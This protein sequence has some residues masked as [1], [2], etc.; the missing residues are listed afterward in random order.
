MEQWASE[1]RTKTQP[2]LLKITTHHGPG[3]TSS[4]LAW[5]QLKLTVGGKE[6]E[7][8]DVVITTFQVLASE[9]KARGQRAAPSD[10]D[11]SDDGLRKKLKRKKKVMAALY[12]V[13]WL[14]IVIGELNKA[15][16]S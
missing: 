1:A 11:D 10:S 4:K 16:L 2:G 8:F 14:R 9:F 3:R 15:G 5:I 12:D 7:K 6:L 13:K